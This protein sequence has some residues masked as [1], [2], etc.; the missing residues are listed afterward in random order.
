MPGGEGKIV[1]YTLAN[2]HR[3]A[4]PLSGPV[5]RETQKL[6]SPVIVA[7]SLPGYNGHGA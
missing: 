6:I 3:Y 4:I 1:L 5:L 2:G 7:G